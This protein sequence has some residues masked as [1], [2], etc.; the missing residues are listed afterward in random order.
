M[1][2][3]LAYPNVR[4]TEAADSSDILDI[5]DIPIPLFCAIGTEDMQVNHMIACVSNF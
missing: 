2:A 3:F 5:P 1:S 4:I